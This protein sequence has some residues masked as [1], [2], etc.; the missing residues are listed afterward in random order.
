LEAADIES[1]K[2]KSLFDIKGNSKFKS[3]DPSKEEAKS[4]HVESSEEEKKG[5]AD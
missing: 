1:P 3:S 5:D 4:K 2:L